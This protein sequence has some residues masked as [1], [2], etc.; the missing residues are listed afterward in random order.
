MKV[1]VENYMG[2]DLTVVNSARVSFDKKSDTL[3][4][5]DKKLIRYLAE[6]G[7]WT[8]FGHCFIQ[9]RIKA[10]IFVS[11]QLVKHQVGLV[12]NE[13]SRRY[14]D[15]IPEFFYPSEWRGRPADKKQG[16]SDK[17]VEINPSGRAGPAMVD[18]YHHAMQKC[19]WTYNQLL[20]R[21]VSPE[22]ARM[23]LPQST[24]TEWYWSGSMFAFS[25]VCNL[26]C[27]ED[28]QQETREI[29]LQ[30]DEECSRLFPVSWTAL[31]KGE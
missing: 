10:P 22:M 8:P 14:V 29:A 1:S 6:N 24:Y 21:G 11:R 12:W 26:R 5:K 16:S 19:L 27:K 7:H 4:P 23:V 9:F 28:A 2:T 18:D 31:R 15:S 20:R 17:I 30:I 13:V 25:R 3:T